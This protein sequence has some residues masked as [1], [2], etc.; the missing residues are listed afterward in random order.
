[1]ATKR[2][3]AAKKT[4]KRKTAVRKTAAKK[5]TRRKPAAPKSMDAVA[6]RKA[7]AEMRIRESQALKEIEALETAKLAVE[8]ERIKVE[9]LRRELIPTT[10]AV[11]AAVKAGSVLAA[12]LTRL[13]GDLPPRLA[14]LDEARIQK[15]LAVDF[16]RLRE[17][18]CAW[19]FTDPDD[20]DD[21]D[22]M[23]VTDGTVRNEKVRRRKELK[24]AA[25]EALAK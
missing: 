16:R 19:D 11:A 22:P 17:E 12:M 5:T 21:G 14:G 1:M 4:A 18:F 13:E 7:V 8:R 24:K 6:R 2:K 25:E 3:T 23:G 10:V 20:L 9:R 15:T